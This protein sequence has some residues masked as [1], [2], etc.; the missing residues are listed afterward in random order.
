MTDYYDM[1]IRHPRKAA[2]LIE[3]QRGQYEAMFAK[4]VVTGER[5][6][7]LEAD[8]TKYKCAAERIIELEADVA[9]YECAADC[10]CKT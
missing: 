8:V 9:E 1:C 4:M 2:A 3:E 5:I 7:K 10:E 6:I